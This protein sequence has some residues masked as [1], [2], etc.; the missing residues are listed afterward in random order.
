MVELCSSPRD[1]TA[2]GDLKVDLELLWPYWMQ[3]L[4]RS[5]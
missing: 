4:R 5:Y 2:A 1:V 3:E